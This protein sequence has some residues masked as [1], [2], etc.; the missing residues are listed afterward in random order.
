MVSSGHE[1]RRA[2]LTAHPARPNR[3]VSLADGGPERRMF[4]SAVGRWARRR[5]PADERL[6][7]VPG[8]SPQ[9]PC[10]CRSGAGFPRR[11]LL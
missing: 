2:G 1:T 7:P 11:R 6:Q 10:K 3:F 9:T 4:R 8:S 5:A